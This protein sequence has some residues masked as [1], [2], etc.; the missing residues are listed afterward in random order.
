MNQWALPIT[1]PKKGQFLFSQLMG[2]KRLLLFFVIATLFTLWLVNGNRVTAE[3]LF[4]SPQSPLSPVE[5]P[6][7]EQPQPAQQSS[8]TEQAPAEQ[9]PA[10]QPP[11]EQPQPAQ[12]SPGEQAPV[13]QPQSAEQSPGE[14]A[15]V[16][17]PSN[18]QSATEIESPD[19]PADEASTELAPPEESSPESNRPARERES[20]TFLDET[21]E[22][23]ARNFI[24]DQVELIDTAVVSG[25]YI[26]LCCGVGLFLLVPMFMLILYIRGRNKV[27]NEEDY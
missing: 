16:E 22:E 8:S 27:I 4:Q 12:Q 20:E 13:E 2:F 7:A 11:A 5:Q 19:A 21:N 24:L 14:Q 26:W 25:A 3:M 6:P 15:P 18:E 9:P 23:T 10:E 17:Q 1:N